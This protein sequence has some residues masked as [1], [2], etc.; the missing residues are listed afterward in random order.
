MDRIY[1]TMAQIIS[2]LTLPG[3]KNEADFMRDILIP[4]SQF[5][6]QQVG[7]FLPRWEAI[8]FSA[9]GA[10][11]LLVPPLLSITSLTSDGNVLTEGTSYVLKPF[12]RHWCNGPYSRICLYQYG[13]FSVAPEGV[14]L[15]GKWGFYDET[16]DLAMTVSAATSTGTSLAVPDGSKCSP[17]MVLLVEAEQMLVEAT[18][19]ATDST[20]DL[21]G[22]LD[23][24]A[25][26]FA[27]TDGT[28]IKTGEVIKV[29][30]EY[31]RV[32][33]V[34]AN[35]V[36]VAR[37]W[38]ESRR[39][40]HLTGAAVNVLRTFTVKR[41]VNGTT[42]ATH[43]NAE[44]FQQVAPGDVNYLARQVASLMKKKADTGFMG[45]SGNDDLGTGFWVNEFPKNQVEA[46]K[47]NYFW[48]GR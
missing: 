40:A 15:N 24:Q 12:E 17:G 31:M 1:C 33:D 18:G 48:G 21:S 25:E 7:Q 34:Q 13:Y 4:S 42:A 5:I 16:R 8:K 20:A 28:K 46:V 38:N 39:A 9:C 32:L 41:G 45:R 35:Q 14:V 11:E 10:T 37:G 36:L 3:I 44:V 2:D 23:D 43:T 29:D 6:E 26:E 27:V 19:A 30:F 47:S 22:A